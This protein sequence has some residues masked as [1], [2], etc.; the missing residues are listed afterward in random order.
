MIETARIRKLLIANRGEIAIRVMRTAAEMGISTVAIAPVDDQ[1]SLHARQG[2]QF[3]LL[4]GRGPA[5]YLDGDDIL[6]VTLATGCDAIHPGYGFLSENAGFARA[7]AKARVLFVGPAPEQLD[8][9]GNKAEARALAVR[10]GVPVLAG[11]EHPV[12]LPQAKDFMA[13]LGRPVMLKALSG[14]GGRGIRLVN[15]VSEIDKAFDRCQS[16]A[17]RSFG[18]NRVYIE[19]A[20][21]KARHVEVQVLGDGAGNVIH[22]G[23]RDCTLQR[24]NQKLVEIAPSPGLSPAVRDQLLEAATAMAS[25]IGFVNAGTFEFLVD[26]EDSRFYFLE[27]NPR[28]QVEHTVTEELW[29]VDLVRAQ[30]LIAS[31]ASL[32]ELKLEQ[33]NC[34]PGFALQ[35]RINMERLLPDGTPVM[36]GGTISLF[37]PPTG[38]GIRVDTFGYSGYATNVAF[39]SLLAK[40][41]VTTRMDDFSVALAKAHR[42]LA[43][44]QIGGVA[45][46]IPFLSALLGHPKLDSAEFSTRFV[47]NH[48]DDLLSAA[49]SIPNVPDTASGYSSRATEPAALEPQ[50]LEDDVQAITSPLAGSVVSILISAGESIAPGQMVAIVEA[51]K[52]EHVIH[53]EAGGVVRDVLAITGA[54]IR[55]GQCIATVA[56]DELAE[57]ALVAADE[58][59]LNF[60]RP[61]LE[62]VLQRQR[63]VLDQQ[64]REAVARRHGKGARTARENVQALCDDGSFVEYGALVVA[65]Q[66]QKRSLEELIRKTPA[67][68][69]VV[70]F[71]N[72]NGTQFGPEKSQSLIIAFDETVLAG[73]MG[74]MCRE[75][76]K[77][78]LSVAHKDRRP[79]ILLAEGGGGRAGDTDGR[80]AITGWTMDVSSYYQLSRM[81]GLTPLIGITSGKCFAANAGMLACCDVIISTRDANIGVGGPSMIEGG[82]LGQF[83]PEQIG[84]MDVQSVNGV[85]DI[86]VADENEAVEIAQKYLSYFQGAVDSW[87]VADQR[88]NR[89][90]VPEN[91][92][93]AYD[94]RKAIDLLADT[95]S[96]LELRRDFGIEIIT[97][98]VRVEGRPLGVIAN[99][100]LHLGGAIHSDGA[101][102]ACRFMNLCQAF[103]LPILFLCDTPGMM[104]GPEAEKSATVRKMGRMFV[105]G[106]NLTVP[107]F[108]IVLRKAYG[109]GAELMTGGWFK[110]PRFVVSWPTGEF[111]GMNIEG[112]VKLAH[113][114][115]LDAIADPV[116][117]QARFEALVAGMH[118][119]GR[120]LSVVTHCEI[121]DVID[122]ADSRKWI[123]NAI[124]THRGRFPGSDKVMPF[125]DPW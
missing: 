20:L 79:V 24:R 17:L 33:K 97:S 41:I 15:T 76:L 93:R 75:K 106:A 113:G 50:T 114:A 49:A 36:D 90:V 78:T 14:G 87:D 89:F 47:D 28:L 23:E 71:G 65:A 30:L 27:A 26:V 7:C 6:R 39:D 22:L 3:E 44:F 102:K 46:N 12:S 45:T 95:D 70:G 81:S 117:R 11:T 72:V 63:G 73:T 103:G 94:I 120:A 55:S 56:V 64:R 40:V 105:T 86:L 31:G 62:E 116:E 67:D 88:A 66:R 19:Q 115:E 37:Q 2:D 4:K 91:R 124:A 108:T 68:G 60:I 112:N 38:P 52:M 35:A 122:P 10:C 107:F 54:M 57:K 111:G 125:V 101:D 85:V 92:L 29:D 9:L 109:I 8:S 98:L 100:P 77:H 82:R 21:L 59:D 123:S 16:E 84:P 83:T 25:A 69:V 110:A 34:R 119:T 80:L 18:D 51:M 58:I 1:N 99:N 32:A 61:D 42:A 43:A 53:A 121:D 118:A 104:V 5:A 96:V 13:A 74:E 48:L